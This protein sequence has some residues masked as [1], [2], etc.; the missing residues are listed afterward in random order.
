MCY[1]SDLLT[2][3]IFTVDYYK[4]V[5]KSAVEAGAHM[6][7]IKVRTFFSCGLL[8]FLGSSVGG[9][10]GSTKAEFSLE[11]SVGVLCPNMACLLFSTR[12]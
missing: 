3:S 1:T 5:V 10:V 4:G 8:S 12:G 9:F 7:G 2:S 11:W 6:I